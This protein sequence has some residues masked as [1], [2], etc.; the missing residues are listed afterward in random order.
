MAT[1]A[2]G[3]VQGCFASLC[4]LLEKVDFDLNKDVLWL[5]GDLVN[6]G[7]DSLSVLRYAMG[8]GERCVCVL[9]NHDLHLLATAAGARKLSPKDTLSPILV[10]EDRLELFD[11]LRHR[12]LLHFD[13][14]LNTAL[15]HAGVAAEWDIDSA[16]RFA[17][18][19][20]G[21]LQS[22]DYTAFFKHMYG[23]KPKRW[24]TDLSGWDRYRYFTNVFTRM[25]YYDRKGKLVLKDK[26]ETD[27][28]P[29]GLTP[30][31]AMPRRAAYGTRIVFGH[32]A[33]L[34]LRTGLEETHNVVHLDTGCVW[35]GHLTA[36]RLEDSREVSVDCRDEG[37][38]PF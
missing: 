38:E 3:D 14:G 21:V 10:A 19:L 18:E 29:A 5:A 24:D 9:G 20:E 25:R 31:F 2:V 11:W 37:I 28:H 6:R 22:D 1:Y 8:L 32:W 35:R 23:N 30:W 16:N 17:R 33:T 15:V 34:P 4:R 7:P 26:G 12:P 27:R 13:K 36:F